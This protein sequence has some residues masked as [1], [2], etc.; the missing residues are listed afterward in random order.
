M[1]YVGI[2]PGAISGAI[3]AVDHDSKFIGAANIEHLNGR[4]LPIELCDLLSNFIDPKEGGEIGIEAVHVMPGQGAVSTGKFMRAAGAIEAVATLT[5][6][7]VTF[8][9]PQTWKKFWGL[10]RDKNDSLL[11]AREKWPKAGMH[12]NKK[13]HHNIAE[14]LLIAEFLRLHING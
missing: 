2:D 3:A 6:Y 1:I 9:T 7:S 5:R 11:L 8:I 10:S 14:A 12:I 13:K 4:I